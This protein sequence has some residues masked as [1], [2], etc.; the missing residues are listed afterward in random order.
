MLGIEGYALAFAAVA[1][2]ASGFL[3]VAL[4]AFGYVVVDY[5]AYVRFVYTHT[6][7]DGGNDDI[8]LLHQE[9]VLVFGTGLG[10]ESGVVG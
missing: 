4:E 6:E 3:I 7:G 5:K 1:S 2:G 8:D 9:F 10:V